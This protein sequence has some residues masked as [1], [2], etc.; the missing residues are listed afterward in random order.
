[1]S[2]ALVEEGTVTAPR[3]LHREHPSH[4]DPFNPQLPSVGGT[5]TVAFRTWRCRHCGALATGRAGLCVAPQSCGKC[6]RR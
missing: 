3:E 5:V 4:K 6:H 1:M 2:F